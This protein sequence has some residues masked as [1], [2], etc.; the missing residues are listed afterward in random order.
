MRKI[1]KAAVPLV[2][3]AGLAMSALTVAAAP[4]DQFS[5]IKGHW[6]QATLSQAYDDGIMK[7]TSATAM[8]PNAS[9][10][11]AQAVTLLCRILQVSGQGDTAELQIPDNAWY[12]QDAAHGVYLGLLSGED[13]GTLD[14]PI[15]RGDAFVLFA[16]AFQNLHALPGREALDRFPDTVTITGETA[17]AA[18]NLIDSG[19]VNGID[20]KLEAG[21]ALTRAEFVT[22]LYRIADVF[23]PSD[24]YTGQGEKGA[25]LSGDGAITDAEGGSLWFDQTVS[26]IHLTDTRA[27]W[28]VVRSDLLTDLTLDGAGQVDT[29]VLSALQG[30]VDLTIPDGFTLG[31]LTVGDGGG[32]VT[33]SGPLPSLEVIGNHRTVAVNTDVDSLVI[34][35]SNNT[36][37]LNNSGE[38]ADRIV[39]TGTGN[40]VILNGK[41]AQLTVSGR[42]NTFSGIGQIAQVDLATRYC[43]MNLS[44]GK[45][46][47]WSNYDLSKVKAVIQ[48]PKTLPAGEHLR[49]VA[50]L[51]VPEEDLGKVCTGAWY[52]NGQKV[53][54]QTV[55]LGQPDPVSDIEVE[56]NHSLQQEA[57]L[58]FELTYRNSDGDTFQTQASSSLYLETF[59]DLGLADA[60]IRLTAP[61]TLS[62]GQ[63]LRV[64]AEVTSPEAG[65]VC[66][67]HWY[68]DGKEVSQGRVTLGAGTPYLNYDFDYYYG[69]P[70]VSQ[71]TCKI[72]YTTQDGREQEISGETGVQVENFPDN[73]IARAQLSL[74]APDSLAAGD[75]LKVTGS[76]TYLEPGK[77][78]AA[79]WYVDGQKVSSQTVTLGTDTPALS[80]KFT[81]TEDMKTTTEIKLVLSYTTQDGRKQEVSAART[82]TLQNYGY[83]HYHGPTDQE[84]LKAVTSTYAGNYTLAW[85]QSHD[86]D[87]ETKTRWVNLQWYSSKTQYLIWVNLTY[88]RVNIFQGSQ[89]NWKLIRCCMCGS[90]KPS[91][92]T[93]KGVFATT[94]KQNSW[95]YGSYYCGPV[96][97]F[98]GGY[99]F[100]S[101]L[102][103]WPMGSGRYYDARIGFPISHGCL[104]MYDD[105]IWWIYNNIPNG[106]TVVVH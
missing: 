20:G 73:G 105:D 65:K 88:Q 30:D 33:V 89:G 36:V 18:E 44:T 92:P 71:I 47:P 7:G 98:Y 9:I 42:D 10:T 58:R 15:T 28:V 104:R 61:E 17:F 85:A 102:E 27:D 77:T 72:T 37:V 31:T 34:S 12:A 62:P 22:M 54:E 19:V 78:C 81:Y 106:T 3:G 1:W 91:T 82:V 48:A 4:A 86:Y 80:H 67:G 76:V 59:E 45:V 41:A 87:A 43:T 51:T 26:S 6:A 57:A 25:V 60:S 24:Q 23:L 95:N 83:S 39:V 5:D 29:L 49:A 69:M 93:I 38:S 96:V 97:R 53:Q 100:H 46:E 101:R 64:T 84:I 56:Y 103:Y 66:T 16:K 99:A 68:V 40:A 79:D 90:G 8:S 94:Y 21:K 2:L 14:Q 11:K 50:R 74:T 13:A 63:T 52:L 75:T 35:G 55:I 70:K 32:K